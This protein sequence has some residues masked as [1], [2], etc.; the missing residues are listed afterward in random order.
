MLFRKAG[1]KRVGKGERKGKKA[2]KVY[3]IIP[4]E[5][6]PR[7]G[8]ICGVSGPMDRLANH[9]FIFSSWGKNNQARA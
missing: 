9:D 6:Y 5:R 7:R 3:I 4:V 8:G 1:N 2:I